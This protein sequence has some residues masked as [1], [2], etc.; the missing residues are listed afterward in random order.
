MSTGRMRGYGTG[1]SAVSLENGLLYANLICIYISQG[2]MIPM[3]KL[4]LRNTECLLESSD[5]L[6]HSAGQLETLQQMPTSTRPIQYHTLGPHSPIASMQSQ[7]SFR[8]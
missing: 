4:L 7:L 3:P 8:C 6:H 2:S 1:E 5:P